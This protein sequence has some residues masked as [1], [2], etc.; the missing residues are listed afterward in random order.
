MAEIV[1]DETAFGAAAE[2]CA[3]Q[4]QGHDRGQQPEHEP[5]IAGPARRGEHSRPSRRA[6]GM[7]ANDP[8]RMSIGFGA[9]RL[10]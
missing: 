4:Q 1:P 3:K 10:A 2:R 7:S 9:P 8:K 6:V 5:K